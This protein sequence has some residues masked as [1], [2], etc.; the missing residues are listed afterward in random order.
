M[1]TPPSSWKMQKA[2]ARGLRAQAVREELL[3]RLANGTRSVRSRRRVSASG[4]TRSCTGADAASAT[5]AE[6]ASFGI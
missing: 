6:A 4:K 2:R 5:T 3:E 1:N